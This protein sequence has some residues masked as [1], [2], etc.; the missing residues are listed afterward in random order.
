MV[1]AALVL[2]SCGSDTPEVSVWL[3]DVWTPMV[4]VVPSP[5]EA[6]ADTCADA[7]ARL[8]ELGETLLPA[9]DPD[10]AAA[11]E[12]WLRRAETLTFDCASDTAGFDYTVDHAELAGH[13]AELAAIVDHRP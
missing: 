6:T 3:A 9:P 4:A 8:R 13:V 12:A 11:A 2:A 5:A 10:I 1:V 7:L